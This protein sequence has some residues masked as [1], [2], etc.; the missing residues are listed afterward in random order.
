M[1]F[2]YKAFSEFY[3]AKL[4]VL[5]QRF[6]MTRMTEIWP[7]V[8]H[9]SLLALGYA[10]PYLENYAAQAE[11]T[12]IMTPNADDGVPWTL[13]A[14]NVLCYAKP[15]LQPFGYESF[16]RIL[17][18][19][20]LEFTENLSEALHESWRVL[21]PNGRMMIIVPNRMS[22]WARTD[23]CPFAYGAPFTVSQIK[24]ALHE[25]NF[26][27][28]RQRKGLFIPPF[29][30]NFMLSLSPFFE[31]LGSS[32]FKSFG[33]VHVIEVSKKIYAPIKPDKGSAIAAAKKILIP[34]KPVSSSN[35]EKRD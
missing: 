29:E 5:A 3:S 27:I 13:Q 35:Y 8:R 2:S 11:R 1:A 16:D 12:V 7:D 28:E 9:H 14:K 20:S 25:N 19:H 26:M 6:I 34:A 31:G 33:G 4:G 24:H 15:T 21:K 17:A 32:V 18:I 23:N 30:T 10:Q 22:T